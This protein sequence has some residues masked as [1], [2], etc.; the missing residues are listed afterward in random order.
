[1]QGYNCGRCTGSITGTGA[2]GWLFL[3][4]RLTTSFESVSGKLKA[5]RKDSQNSSIDCLRRNPCDLRISDGPMDSISNDHD[6]PVFAKEKRS[7]PDL[8][9][10]RRVTDRRENR[11]SK[12]LR[13]QGVTYAAAAAATDHLEPSGR[14]I[15]WLAA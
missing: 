9:D 8:L 14:V 2:A 6:G 3:C 10:D 12:F 7:D 15:A 1:M 11:V 13:A 4:G 5:P